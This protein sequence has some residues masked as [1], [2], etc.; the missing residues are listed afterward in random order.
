MGAGAWN[1]ELRASTTPRKNGVTAFYGEVND[2]VGETLNSDGDG[3]IAATQ[4]FYG[5]TVGGGEL[6]IGLLDATG[7]LDANEIADDEYSQFLGGSFVNNPSI[8][9]PSFA[10]GLNYRGSISKNLGYQVFVSSTGGLE[11]ENNPTYNNVVN[12]GDGGKSVFVGSE[13]LVNV[14]E[15]YGSFGAW[16]NGAD[17]TQLRNTVINNKD[18]Y[19]GYISGGGVLGPGQWAAWGGIANAK[20]SPAANFIGAAYALD[21]QRA[22]LGVG[23]ARIGDSDYLPGKTNAIVQ[24]EI[25]LRINVY[26]SFYVTPDLQYVNNS[27]FD[28]DRD[29]VFVGGLRAGLEF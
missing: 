11:D 22:T 16:Y 3:R 15:T 9:Y 10:L 5:L 25:Y 21:I 29:G 7:L 4:L 14:G 8:E 12:V 17:H 27:G 24:A 19:G 1:L 23:L 18:N 26:Q 20:V 13:L 2:A 6:S 28:P